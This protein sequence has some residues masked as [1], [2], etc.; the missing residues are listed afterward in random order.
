MNKLDS[1]N[2][3]KDIDFT[4]TNKFFYSFLRKLKRERWIF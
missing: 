1:L 4:F 2:K 3:Y